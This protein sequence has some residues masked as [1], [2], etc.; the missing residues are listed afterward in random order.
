VIRHLAN[1]TM[2]RSLLDLDEMIKTYT[3]YGLSELKQNH[4]N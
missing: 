3:F 2:A 4:S 1:S